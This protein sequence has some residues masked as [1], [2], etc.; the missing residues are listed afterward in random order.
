MIDELEYVNFQSHEGTLLQ[1]HQG[2][3]VIWGQ[4][5]KGKSS[6]VRGLEWLTE[7]RPK[8]S[9]FK[10]NFA[11]DAETFVRA[12][13]TEGT[14]VTRRKYKKKNQYFINDEE[15]QAVRSDVPDEIRE[16]T[17]M[18]S[19]NIQSQKEAYFLL[20][21]TPGQVA[22][23]FNSAVD[24]QEMDDV[25]TIINTEVLNLEKDLAGVEKDIKSTQKDFSEYAW[26]AEAHEM[27]LHIEARQHHLNLVE[28]QYETILTKLDQIEEYQEEI[29]KLP[30]TAPLPYLNE[31]LQLWLKKKVLAARVKSL[32]DPII[33][34]A[35]LRCALQKCKAPIT[36]KELDGLVKKIQHADSIHNRKQKILDKTSAIEVAQEELEQLQTVKQELLADLGEIMDGLDVCPF[37]EQE[38]PK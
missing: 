12:G 13:Y 6:L 31:L 21:K 32:K 8:G 7:N 24:L 27:L 17:R 25:K 5:H 36:Q 11:K 2:V 16:I 23:E 20:D 1:L 35:Y 30:D 22:K 38:M 28:E 19:I 26:L 29:N 4:S 37:C 33:A 3:N 9:K 34:D 15:L 14:E 18:D 10:S